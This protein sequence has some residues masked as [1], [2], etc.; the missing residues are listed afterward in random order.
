MYICHEAKIEN[1]ARLSGTCDNGLALWLSIQI[2][3]EFHGY[4]F[5]TVEILRNDVVFGW[6]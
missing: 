4:L 3:T 5:I 1:N 2:T 6:G